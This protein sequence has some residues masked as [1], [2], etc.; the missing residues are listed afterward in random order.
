MSV[1]LTTETCELSHVLSLAVL[2][3]AVCCECDPRYVTYQQMVSKYVGEGEACRKASQRSQIYCTFCWYAT[4][5]IPTSDFE[6]LVD[7]ARSACAAAAATSQQELGA[8]PSRQTMC[9]AGAVSSG[10][11]AASAAPVL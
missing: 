4:G 11:A 6:E 8:S 7:Y 10:T 9:G 2:Y 1:R 5:R 3:S